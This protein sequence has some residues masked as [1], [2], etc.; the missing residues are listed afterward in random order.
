[1]VAA[2]WGATPFVLYGMMYG[3]VSVEKHQVKG[4]PLRYLEWSSAEDGP[5]ALP[6]LIVAMVLTAL[7]HVPGEVDGTGTHLATTDRR[8]LRWLM[9]WLL[10]ILLPTPFDADLPADLREFADLTLILGPLIEE[11]GI[12]FRSSRP[13]NWV[14]R[15]V[16]AFAHPRNRAAFALGQWLMSLRWPP[17]S[18][19]GGKN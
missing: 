10:P 2:S 17:G 1:M 13:A 5:L 3:H 7:G 4:N 16:R 8:T 18:K 14:T 12:G 19:K 9:N 6:L 11:L 15:R